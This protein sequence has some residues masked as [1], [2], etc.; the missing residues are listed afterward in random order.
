M[1]ARELD[2]QDLH[3]ASNEQLSPHVLIVTSLPDQLSAYKELLEGNGFPCHIFTDTQK[4]VAYSNSRSGCIAFL[5]W[6][7]Q[8]TNA[9]KDIKSIESLLFEKQ[10]GDCIIFSDSDDVQSRAELASC[11]FK[12][13]IQPPYNEK[14]FLMAVS[15]LYALKNL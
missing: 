13:T 9:N 10:S 4:A 14:N 5:N 11:G 1:S 7:L 15:H 3:P 12:Q 8:K 6:D 2:L